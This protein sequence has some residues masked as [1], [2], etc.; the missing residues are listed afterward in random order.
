MSTVEST[1]K[2]EEKPLQPASVF[3]HCQDPSEFIFVAAQG[4]LA[5]NRAAMVLA[6]AASRGVPKFLRT[7]SES[8]RRFMLDTFIPFE[9]ANCLGDNLAKLLRCQTSKPSSSD[10]DGKSM[11]MR[12]EV[13]CGVALAVSCDMCTQEKF[14]QLIAKDDDQAWMDKFVEVGAESGKKMLDKLGASEMPPI[15][16]ELLKSLFGDIRKTFGDHGH[17]SDATDGGPNK[18]VTSIRR[19]PKPDDFPS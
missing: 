17:D 7:D 16:K 11:L 12:V 9:R 6:A 10:K 5:G 13:I 19:G 1:E 3:D 2:Q 15:V 8:G 4:S 14:E 18:G